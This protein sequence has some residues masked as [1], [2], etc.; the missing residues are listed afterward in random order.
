MR[1]M[2][3]RMKPVIEEFS[4]IELIPVWKTREGETEEDLDNRI[5]DGLVLQIDENY[6]GDYIL[7]GMQETYDKAMDNYRKIAY[8]LLE[9]GYCEDDDF[10]NFQWR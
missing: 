3:D 7:D 1:I 4:F 9:K 2:R 6:I 5:P 10:E 8:Q